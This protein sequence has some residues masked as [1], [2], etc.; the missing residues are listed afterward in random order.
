MSDQ[1][2]K[3]MQVIR[4]WFEIVNTGDYGQIMKALEELFTDDYTLHD[5][6]FPNPK[7]G[8]DI[9]KADGDQWLMNNSGIHMVIEDL[10]GMGDKTATRAALECV[11]NKTQK[12]RKT[13]FI[14]F[15]RFENGKIAE[16]WQVT[17]LIS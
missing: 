6:S 3:N 4:N 10:M 11:D 9:A 1:V 15:S 16:E 14:F 17:A 13:V 5:P 7:R 8:K 12:K 2:Q